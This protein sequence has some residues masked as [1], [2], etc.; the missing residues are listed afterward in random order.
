MKPRVKA[1]TSKA[2]AA[3]R[4]ESFIRAYISNG[5]NATQAAITAGFSAKTAIVKGSQLLTE[6]NV[7][8]RIA[9]LSEKTAK[10]TGLDMER[11]LREV[12]RLGYSDTRK[13]YTESGNLKDPADWDDDTAAAVSGV[14]IT[15]EFEGRGEDRIS[16]GFTKKVKLWDKGAALEKAMKFHG[17]YEKDNSQRGESIQIQVV[18]V[19]GK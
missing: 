17:L 16:T 6:V 4:R 19:P 5:Q 10:I 11:T 8:A 9:E 12:A 2:A 13:L 7:K 15:E 14:E 1:G 18:L 3:D